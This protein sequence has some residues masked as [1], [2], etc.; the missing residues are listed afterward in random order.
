MARMVERRM[1]I[2]ACHKDQVLVT[3]SHIDKLENIMR[4][5]QYTTSYSHPEVVDSQIRDLILDP[6]QGGVVAGAV[7]LLHEVGQVGHPGQF[8]QMWRCKMLRFEDHGDL[9]L[10][11]RNI[12]C[13]LDIFH[14]IVGAQSLPI[15]KKT[16][17]TVVEERGEVDPVVPVGGEVL[18]FT[19]R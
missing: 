19:V 2:F 6:V 18:D 15:R 3:C 9:K 12:H 16:R 1:R 4:R 14:A 7:L 10:S 5:V 13:S 8:V 17:T 11:F